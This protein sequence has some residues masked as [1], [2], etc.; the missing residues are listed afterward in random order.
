MSISRSTDTSACSATHSTYNGGYSWK[1]TGNTWHDGEDD[2][3]VE[4]ATIIFSTKVAID[5][6]KFSSIV[7]TGKYGTLGL[8][9]TPYFNTRWA[10]S[11]YMGNTVSTKTL[12]I[13]GK[14]GMF[15]VCFQDS[16]EGDGSSAGNCTSIILKA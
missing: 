1:L 10:A 12:D 2:E 7:F 4:S 11:L 15:Y 9:S 16:Q 3:E 13:S 6:T 14:T 8:K 5:V